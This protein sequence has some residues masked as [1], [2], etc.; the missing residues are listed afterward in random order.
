V[1]NDDIAPV[2]DGRRPHRLLRRCALGLLVAYAIY[3]VVANLLLNTGPGHALANM[4]PEKFQAGWERAV[5][6]LPG[7]VTAWNLKLAGNVRRTVWSVQA[8]VVHGRIELLPLLVKQ[9]RISGLRGEAVS[10]G[11]TRIDSGRPP[12]EPRPGGWKLFL[13]DIEVESLRHA[14][15][16]DLVLIGTGTATTGIRKTLRGGPTEL[17][18]SHA[19]VHD[20]ILWWDGK[21]LLNETNLQVRF[22]MAANTRAEAPGIQK[23]LKMDL[24][25]AVSA[26]SRGLELVTAAGERP[27]VVTTDD[28]GR[29]D[30]HLLWHKGEVGEGSRLELTVPV[31]RSAAGPAQPGQAK[32][33]L[34]APADAIRLSAVFDAGG[35]TD[36][37]LL[38]DL[39]VDG[40]TIPLQPGSVTAVLGRSSGSIRGRW[41]FDDL[42]WLPRAVPAAGRLGIQGKGSVEADVALAGGVVASGSRISVPELSILSSTDD[43][44]LQSS[45]HADLLLEPGDTRGKIDAVLQAVIDHFELS[46][47]G[48]RN[49]PYLEGRGLIVKAKVGSEVPAGGFPYRAEFGLPTLL[50]R[51]ATRELAGSAKGDLQFHGQVAGE[52]FNPL[53]ARVEIR[54]GTLALDGTRL[55]RNAHAIAT[56]S[57]AAAVSQSAR[58]HTA[59][60]GI[61][62][63]AEL[64]AGVSGVRLQLGKGQRARL[65]AVNDQGRLDGR[66]GLHQGALTTGSS[67]RI[68]TPVYSTDP[69]DRAPGHVDLTLDVLEDAV[70]IKAVAGSGPHTDFHVQGDFTFHGRD[71]PAPG[72]T[73]AALAARV[74]GKLDGHWRFD[75]LEWLSHSLQTS[76][77]FSF[78]GKGRV[79]GALRIDR[80]RI[81]E[82]SRVT[83]P[84]VSAVLR[85]MDNEFRGDARADILFEPASRPGELRPH[86]NALMETFQ[87]MPATAPD[88]PYVRGRDLA[89]EVKVDDGDKPLRDLYHAHVRFSNAE[90]PDLSVYNRYLPS[91]QLRL[92]GGSGRL[93]G[94][95]RL[96]GS[97]RAAD[98]QLKVRGQQARMDLAGIGLLGNIAADTRLKLRSRSEKEHRFDLTGSQIEVSDVEVTRPGEAPIAGWW[99]AL[100]FDDAVID[101]KEAPEVSASLRAQMKDLSVLLALYS[102]QKHFPKWIASVVDDG[103][104]RMTGRIAWSRP[105]LVLDHFDGRNDRF[106]AKARLRLHDGQRDGNL[107]V[108]W[109]KLG[110]GL[111]LKNGGKDFRFVKPREWYESQPDLLPQ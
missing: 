26:D 105:A 75:D 69:A 19:E 106:Q 107:Y 38:S 22:A 31:R 90:V 104:A 61:E 47:S 99:A 21:R 29:L 59:L 30:A 54:D 111:D 63:D 55:L 2:T 51:T 5:T 103:E 52:P 39:V 110:L 79:D 67:V 71:W 41:H 62:V 8:D 4:K 101:M 45:L 88:K 85:A 7:R 84:R 25:I 86:V 81:L 100:H 27:Q 73:P 83:V 109:H 94:D 12:S 93:S 60:E 82:T 108:S 102:E 68:S 40:R 35:Q 66:I 28:P 65:I 16:N 80:G 91:T 24:D 72:T 87:V 32:L 15:F 78:A 96:D 77:L 53:P 48:E 18:P 34:Q 3:L 74:S 23:L 46:R 89:L 56:L 17:L 44:Q 98:A 9:I 64:T 58:T 76:Q 50:F 1:S 97:G 20:A 33:L 6:Y 13:E 11:A 14:Y 57:R 70:G 42:A 36:F 43:R 92:L 95:L 37:H 10:G 49:R